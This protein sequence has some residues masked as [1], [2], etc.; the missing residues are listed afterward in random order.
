MS[1]DEQQHNA[2]IKQLVND[3]YREAGF[4]EVKNFAPEFADGCQFERLF[5]LLYKTEVQCEIDPQTNSVYRMKNW[6]KING[7]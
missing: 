2:Q 7:K 4:N 3:I 5:N 6:K 1:R